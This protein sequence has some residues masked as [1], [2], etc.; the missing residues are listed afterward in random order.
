MRVWEETDTPL[1]DYHR[2]SIA[3]VRWIREQT[4]AA[5]RRLNLEPRDY[6]KEGSNGIHNRS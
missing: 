1:D 4:N 6:G 2:E 5:R 3:A